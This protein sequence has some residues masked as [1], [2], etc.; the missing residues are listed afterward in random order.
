MTL[1]TK[2]ISSS[3]W[4][5]LLILVVMAVVFSGTYTYGGVALSAVSGLSSIPVPGITCRIKGN[6][7]KSGEKIYHKPGQKYFSQTRI[8]VWRGERYF[9]S[10]ADARRAGWRRSRV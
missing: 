5:G 7:S 9:C 3:R 8:A 4:N 2:P 1:R 10:E 6:I